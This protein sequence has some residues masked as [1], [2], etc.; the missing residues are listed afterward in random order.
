MPSSGRGW[1]ISFVPGQV[2]EAIFARAL[3]ANRYL[4]PDYATVAISVEDEP[5]AV[6]GG[7]SQSGEKSLL[8]HA[9]QKFGA[10]FRPDAASLG[11]TFYLGSRE[12]M[13]SAEQRGTALWR[14]DWGRRPGRPCGAYHGAARFL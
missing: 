12:K 1:V 8:A 11:I 10:P 7:D 6:A 3:T 13:L 2:L 14:A 4:V 5:L 9:T